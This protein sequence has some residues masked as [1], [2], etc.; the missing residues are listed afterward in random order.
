MD[1]N[2]LKFLNILTFCGK[3]FSRFVFLRKILLQ[4]VTTFVNYFIIACCLLISFHLT[5]IL[6]NKFD[7]GN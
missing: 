5:G 1:I 2:F 4:N 7:L 3:C 6:R